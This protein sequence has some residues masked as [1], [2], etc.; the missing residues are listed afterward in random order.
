[1][2]AVL[3]EMLDVRKMKALWPVRR[4]GTTHPTMQHHIA[5]ELNH[6]LKLILNLN[7]LFKHE[8]SFTK[9]Q[10]AGTL[11]AS[12]YLFARLRFW[13]NCWGYASAGLWRCVGWV[14]P[15]VSRDCTA[16]FFKGSRN[17]RRQRRDHDASNAMHPTTQ[18][19]MCLYKM[20][21]KTEQ[22]AYTILFLFLTQY[23]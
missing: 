19:C 3:L 6:L 8:N 4:L 2:L 14:F 15:V 5:Q 18:C 10:I 12:S 23:T 9:C 22:M 11:F 13:Q 7:A 21:C 17:P 20:A 1:M 16:F